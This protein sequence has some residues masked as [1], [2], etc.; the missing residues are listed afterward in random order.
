MMTTINI[1]L[2]TSMYEDMKRVMSQ[3]GYS[4]IS[5]LVRETLRK[6]IY[7]NLTVNGFTPEFEEQVLKAAKEPLKNA[8]VWN[9]KG[10]FTDF[11]LKKG[12]KIHAKD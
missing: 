12:K 2:P 3:R 1:S 7:P 10:S 5:E 11:V 9:G 4:S 8:V 6:N